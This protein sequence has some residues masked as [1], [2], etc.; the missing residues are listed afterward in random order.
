M[1]KQRSPVEQ[2][3]FVQ[4]LVTEASPL[5]YPPNASL[6]EVNFVLNRDGTRQRRLGMDFEE[7]H[8]VINSTV[9]IPIDNDVVFSA[10][11][12]E[13][14][15]GDP[16]VEVG[17]V[18][19]GNILK[20][21]NT[22]ASNISSNLIFTYDTGAPVTNTFS[23][24][25]VDGIL[26]VTT[27][28]KSILI[29]KYDAGSITTSTDILRIRDLF[30]I[31]DKDGSVDLNQGSG[32]T[33]RPATLS[34]EHRYNL[35][36]QSF[37]PPRATLTVG[38]E[39]TI[40]EYLNIN[41][42][43]PS[44][45]DAVYYNLYPDIDVA[46][47][48]LERFHAFDLHSSPPGTIPAARGHFI[49]DALE[50][51]TS[52][53]DE[54]TL[55]LSRYPSLGHTLTVIPLDETPDGATVVAE[56]AG[57]AWFGG[58]SG[59][60]DGADEKTPYLSSYIMF[61]QLIDDITDITKCYQE[62]DP[63][64][65]NASDII[66]TDGGFIRIAGA[67]GIVGM[68]TLGTGL[69]V[70]AANGVWR[71]TGGDSGFDATDYKVQ[72]ITDHGSTSPRSIVEV[73]GGVAYWG[74]DGIYFVAVNELGD[75]VAQNVSQNSIQTVYNSI[76]SLD[77]IDCFGL[78]DSYDRK[79][80]WLYKNRIGSNESVEELVFDVNLNAFYPATIPT[81]TGNRPRPVCMI[82]VP[83]FIA[84]TVTDTVEVGGVAVEAVTDPVTVSIP[85]LDSSLR[86]IKYITLTDDSATNE[87]QYT[88]S[89][90][91]DS[92][93]LDWKEYDTVGVDA[94]AYMLTGYLTGGDSQRK[95]SV[96]YLTFHMV[97]T[98]DGFEDVGGEL[99]PT[100]QSSCKVQSQWEWTNSSN[101]NRWGREFQA[102]RYN[103]LYFPV[104]VDDE[105][106]T[107]HLI[108]TTKN[109]IRGKG[110]AL[111]FLIKTEAGK[112]CK[113]LGWSMV[114]GVEGNV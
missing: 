62:G 70:I 7:D 94:Q 59:H 108:I 47:K 39:D 60:V 107:G 97:R 106:D 91:K 104:D 67:Y 65:K 24:A 45:S 61:S 99:I 80:R 68:K 56:F 63:T 83:P 111:S 78:Y 22:L 48:T 46:N 102:Y 85:V 92:D 105:F 88:F 66:A 18:Q 29:F 51:G 16:A 42:V 58:F 14:A 103:R 93:F 35:R 19:T 109:K 72:K 79:V 32:I 87:L 5:N 40:T 28:Q 53:L 33:Q 114:M 1:P 49:I 75:Y 101:S 113:I 34:E 13:N 71:I 44:N 2:V 69:V 89:F 26:V 54:Y 110:R 15:G 36:N 96:S 86:E 3:S 81:I 64:S 41:S 38:A 8:T 27:G 112:D 17:V 21:F 95:K 9:V 73:D 20:F 50:R 6:D 74:D 76:A 57:R 90:Y 77:K 11:T 37:G 52:R 55:L 4:G 98:E 100:N 23:F 12:W 30:G 43:Y 31:E 10:Y 25:A 82:K 84:S